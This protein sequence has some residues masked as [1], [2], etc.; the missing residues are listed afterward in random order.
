VR[1]LNALQRV[2]EDMPRWLQAL[3]LVASILLLGFSIGY[4]VAGGGR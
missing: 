1:F 4:G 2:I 3:I